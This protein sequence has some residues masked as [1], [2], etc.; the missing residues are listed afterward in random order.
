[1]VSFFLSDMCLLCCTFIFGSWL[2]SK[3]LPTEKQNSCSY[4]VLF[5]IGG[6]AFLPPLILT[7]IEFTY[8]FQRRLILCIVAVEWHFSRLGKVKHQVGL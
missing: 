7:I 5:I 4:I 8:K 3:G 2:F 6:G 1:M